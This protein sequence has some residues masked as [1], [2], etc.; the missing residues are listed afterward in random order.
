MSLFKK[1]FG[2]TRYLQLFDL[3][4]ISNFVIKKSLFIARMVIYLEKKIT[5]VKF[6]SR[7]L[8]IKDRIN[9]LKNISIDQKPLYNILAKTCSDLKIF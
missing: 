7:T 4:N 3:K 9:Y 5:S 8:F 6:L 1:V 2:P